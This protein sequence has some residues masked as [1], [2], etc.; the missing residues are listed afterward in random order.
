[1]NTKNFV[2]E[3]EL[4]QMEANGKLLPVNQTPVVNPATMRGAPP[5]PVSQPPQF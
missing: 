5:T 3:S 4:A 1:M 2:T